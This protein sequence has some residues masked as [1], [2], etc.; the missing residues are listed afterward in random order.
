MADTGDILVLNAGSSSI[1]FAVFDG[2]LIQRHK[3]IASGIGTGA[4]SGLVI[5]GKAVETGPLGD[6]G[7]ALRVVLSALGDVGLHLPSLAGAAHRVVHGGRAL[8]APVRVT[9]DV[10]RQIEAAVPLAPLHN[11]HNLAAIRAL[12][13]LA[14]ELPQFASF[15]TAFH[16]TAP[17]VARRY[18]IPA[19][20]DADGLRRYGFHGISYASVVARFP[21]VTGRPLPERVLV[22][23]LGNGASICAVRDGRSVATTMGYSPLDGLTMGTRA[24][25]IDASAALAMAERLGLAETLEVLNAQSGLLALSGRTSDMRAL[26]A[27]PS[28]EAAFAVEH[29]NYWAARQAGSLM[30]ALGG[31]DAVV[32]TGGIGE[33]AAPVRAGI[34]RLLEWAGVELDARANAAGGP[35]IG[36]R[37]ARAGAWVIPTAEE[38]QIAADALALM[39]EA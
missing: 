31:L 27:D 14:P 33:N 11:P 36:A 10:C 34:G 28:P 23:H 20:F 4:E 12:Q 21:E 35:S 5:D 24:G 6:H 1:K 3:G 15:D 30:T 13:A 29:F 18:A 17:E 39:Q 38:R 19:R 25:A 9:E 26:L 32:F 16:A 2:R 37:S 22:F 8:T 7:D